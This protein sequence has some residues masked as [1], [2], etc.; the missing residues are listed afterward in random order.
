MIDY[1]NLHVH[2]SYS[3]AD[4][5]VKVEQLFKGA[6]ELGQSSIALTE[7]GNCASLVDAHKASKK[8]GVKFTPGIEAYFIDDVK[9]EAKQKRRHIILLAK[10]EVG[11]RNILKLN[12]AGFQHNQ[13][14][15]VLNKVFPRID[16]NLLRQYREGVICSTACTSGIIA[17]KLYRDEDDP[18]DQEKCIESAEQAIMMLKDI[19][20]D[21]LYFELQPH[22]LKAYAT[23][24]KT[25][26]PILRDGKQIVV[27]DQLEYNRFLIAAAKRFGV[28]YYA[29]CDVHYLKKEDAVYHD[30]LLA[31]NN[32]V[33]ISDP[34]RQKYSVNEFYLKSG[35]EVYD[36]FETN[37]SVKVA[38]EA[39]ANT[40]RVANKCEPSDYLEP[41]GPRFPKFDIHAEKDYPLF[42]VQDDATSTVP[43]D[44]RF[45]R[46]KVVKALKEQFKHLSKEDKQTYVERVKKEL[47][48][49]E[50]HNFC[51]YMLI[52]SDF[53]KQARA[54]GVR[55]GPGRGSAAGSLVAFLLRI[56]DVNPITYNLLFERFH[57]KEKKAFP[58]I[59]TDLDPVGRDWVEQY[60]VSKYGRDQVAHVSNLSRMTPKV[61]IKDLARSLELGGSKSEAFKIANKITD[62][63]PADPHITIDDA[64]AQ[65]K[66]FRE[67]C[68]Q[69]PQLE[70][71]GR[72]LD[73]L[74]K[75]YATHAAGI[76]IGDVDLSTIVPLRIDKNGAV[77]V[78]Y[79]K[80]R[81]EEVGLIKMDLLGLEHLRIVDN[82]IKNAQAL[83]QS[84]PE[85]KDIPLDDAAVWGDLA[86]GFTVGVF[87]MG[88]P[89]MQELCKRIKPRNIEDLSL[90]NALGRPSAAKSRDEYIGRRDRRLKV[91]YKY[92]CLR[93]PLEDSLGIVVYEEQMMKLG[94]LV[95][96][97]DLNRCDNFRK[98]AKYKNK[99]PAFVEK[100]R[101]DFIADAGS[102]SGLKE[103]EAQDIWDNVIEPLSQYCFNKSHSVSYSI[104][105]YHT[106]YYRHYFP[107]AFMAALLKSE[108]DGNGQDRES[109]VRLYKREARRLGLTI[110]PPNVNRSQESYSVV[111]AKTLLIGLTAIKGLGESAF[112]SILEARTQHQFTSF[113]DFLYRTESS[114]VKK[115]AIQALAKSG[116]FDCLNITR[117]S[118][119]TY[120]QDIRQR[121]NKYGDANAENGIAEQ[122]CLS[123]FEFSREDFYDEWPKKE[124]LQGENEVLGEFVSGGVVDVYGDFFTAAGTTFD[125]A[126]NMPDKA[127]VRV[128]AILVDLTEATF[129]SGKQKG[130][131]YARC[132]LSDINSET[133]SLTIWNESY[134]RLKSKLKVGQPLKLLCVINDWNNTK[135]LALVDLES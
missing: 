117:K 66:E 80:N 45:L 18:L 29:A 135:T 116:A 27:I 89:H 94:S 109:N 44:H 13:Y 39:C 81:C 21:D 120:Y 55:I 132:T 102:V 98:L 19:Y 52:V 91:E 9:D 40:I 88:S 6:K 79:E 28:K 57:N 70:E 23:D 111:D 126:K 54:N 122:H 129:K 69:Y 130:K 90:V 61:T 56:H 7:H 67:C 48:V 2:S 128:E 65:S 101:T 41:I 82:T 36:Y 107:A 78:Q 37:F 58:D 133:M 16:W 1:C 103:T 17:R 110:I 123:G 124:L 68:A 31:I 25:G 47:S 22:N 84:C 115:D 5:M 77:S 121:A 125:R 95:A 50:Q 113:A 119:H 33:P 93:K 72:K 83:G 10:N 15:A 64:L 11:Y 76:V 30:A 51:S 71:Y 75:N 99:D 34:N 59:D 46:F 100:L 63:I 73:G 62:T 134:L 85:P 60:I 114:K 97:W 24:R 3:M 87:Q 105:G 8:Y 12:Y 26:E 96:G 112:K 108:S 4:S 118:A 14:V 86:K 104:N 92:E 53:I 127:Q 20:Q 32:R 106:A 35:Q 131:Q 49:L 42:A 38:K 43:E 74:E